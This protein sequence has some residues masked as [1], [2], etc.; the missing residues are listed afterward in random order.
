MTVGPRSTQPPQSW[1]TESNQ[2]GAL[3]DV[4][5]A[6][7]ARG[8]HVCLRPAFCQR[9]GRRRLG[10]QV[11]SVQATSR[12]PSRV[13]STVAFSKNRDQ[14]PLDPHLEL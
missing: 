2:L 13:T 5:L 10:V 12:R 8:V 1:D 11:V 3:Q 9:A 4:R 7:P 6:T 14:E